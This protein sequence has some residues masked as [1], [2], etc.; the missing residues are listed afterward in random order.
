MTPQTLAVDES[1]TADTSLVPV[2]NYAI[3]RGKCDEFANA[4]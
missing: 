1:A 3:S 2:Y 4:G